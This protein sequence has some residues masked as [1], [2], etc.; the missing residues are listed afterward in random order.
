MFPVFIASDLVF[1]AALLKVL[2]RLGLGMSQCSPVAIVSVAV[3]CGCSCVEA[4]EPARSALTVAWFVGPS[5][6]RLRPEPE[7]VAPAMVFGLMLAGA[8][9]LLTCASGWGHR[10]LGPP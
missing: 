7:S 1:L 3:F 9:A 10:L 6:R 2:E 8:M 5:W 4:L